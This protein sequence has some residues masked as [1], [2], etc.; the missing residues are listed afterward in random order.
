[1]KAEKVLEAQSASIREHLCARLRVKYHPLPVQQPQTLP[2]SPRSPDAVQALVWLCATM[3]FRSDVPGGDVLGQG[4][5]REWGS[6][7]V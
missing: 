4:R 5:V 3:P 6:H 1:M 2:L 7:L